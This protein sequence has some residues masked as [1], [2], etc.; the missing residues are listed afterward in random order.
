[1]STTISE[2]MGKNRFLSN[3]YKASFVWAGR[4]WP[5]VEHAY[6]AAKATGSNTNYWVDVMLSVP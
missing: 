3:F 6:Q 4:Q 1:M 2:F 5:T